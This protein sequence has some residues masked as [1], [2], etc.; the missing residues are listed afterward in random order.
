MIQQLVHGD[1]DDI[2]EKIQGFVSKGGV[3]TLK[4]LEAGPLGSNMGSKMN[5]TQMIAQ[6]APLYFYSLEKNVIS[7]LPTPHSKA[8]RMNTLRHIV[9]PELN[10]RSYL[11]CRSELALSTIRYLLQERPDEATY[12]TSDLYDLSEIPWVTPMEWE[13]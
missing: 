10:L 12:F 6:L 9:Y 3:P 8:E 5:I 4:N 1:A 13:D 2:Q 11:A 7:H